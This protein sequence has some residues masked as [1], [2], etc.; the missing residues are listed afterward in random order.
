MKY[1][2]LL[3]GIL[4]FADASSNF[5]TGIQ[6]KR[7]LLIDQV[8]HKQNSAYEY[9]KIYMLE[10][11]DLTPTRGE[12]QTRFNLPLDFWQNYT[13]E[14]CIN[15]GAVCS[16]NTS[17]GMKLIVDNNSYSVTLENVLGASTAS[18]TNDEIF[19]YKTS[20]IK[21]T[22]SDRLTASGTGVIFRFDNVLRSTIVMAKRIAT[23]STK[24]ISEVAP[25]DVSKAWY[26]P[27]GSNG[28]FEVYYFDIIDGNWGYRGIMGAEEKQLYFTKSDTFDATT[29]AG[30]LGDSANVVIDDAWRT[31]I[32]DGI[33]W[34]EQSGGKASVESQ[35]INEIGDLDYLLNRASDENYH[36]FG[37]QSGSTFRVTHSLLIAG[38]SNIEFK[39]YVNYWATDLKI[40]VPNFKNNN[41]GTFSSK[42]TVYIV[43][44]TSKLPSCASGDIFYLKDNPLYHANTK[45]VSAPEYEGICLG[46][47]WYKSFNTLERLVDLGAISDK[48][49]VAEAGQT[50]TKNESLTSVGYWT[51]EFS[52]FDYLSK[53]LIYVTKGDRT[54]MPNAST[55]SALYISSLFGSSNVVPTPPSLEK[56]Y[57]LN[58]IDSVY[59]YG[60]GFFKRWFYATSGDRTNNLL[61]GLYAKDYYNTA[62]AGLHIVYPYNGRRIDNNQAWKTI[63]SNWIGRWE[64]YVYNAYWSNG[65]TMNQSNQYVWMKAYVNASCGGHQ[66]RGFISGRDTVSGVSNPTGSRYNVTIRRSYLGWYD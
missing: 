2:I 56:S 45:T 22:Q 34:V 29:T 32:H 3:V 50:F 10:T 53:G 36:F 40:D 48:Y 20:E 42:S 15:N 61:D 65:T 19:R 63:Y 49:Y 23:S 6:K 9:T 60:A 30:T 66:C 25:L 16:N 31:Y 5:E 7:R 47:V 33:K 58:G 1:V 41:A 8:I 44:D 13:K 21:N 64:A 57:T 17:G 28:G 62:S 52:L 39:R 27:N 46:G 51:N 12:I 35:V 11:G 55:D 54:D 14:D 24:I 37:A 59:V 38:Q 18:L 26:K 43:D 4:F